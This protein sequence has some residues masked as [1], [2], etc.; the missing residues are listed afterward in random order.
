VAHA[1]HVSLSRWSCSCSSSS[2]DWAGAHQTPWSPRGDRV[3]CSRNRSAGTSGSLQ[4]R[5]ESAPTIQLVGASSSPTD[6][7]DIARDPARN[8]VNYLALNGAVLGGITGARGPVVGRAIPRYM[9]I[10]PSSLAF[11]PTNVA[12]AMTH[13]DRA[14]LILSPPRLRGSYC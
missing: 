9:A 5:P 6:R 7:A 1:R 10:S 12:A 11:S 3:P 4:W 2:S 8:A 14:L 13:I